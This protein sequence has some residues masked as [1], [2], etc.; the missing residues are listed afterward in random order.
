MVTTEETLALYVLLTKAGINYQKDKDPRTALIYM[1]I[2]IT[3]RLNF[4]HSIIRSEAHIHL[5]QGCD[6]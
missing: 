5:S 1:N 6:H 2:A 3:S 4:P